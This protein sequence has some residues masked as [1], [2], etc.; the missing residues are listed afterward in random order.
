MA[1]QRERGQ[2]QA[3]ERV[4]GLA[5]QAKTRT[6]SENRVERDIH[7]AADQAQ[8]TMQGATQEVT[9][10]MRN[11]EVRGYAYLAAGLILLAYALGWF[12]ILNVVVLAGAIFGAL[13]GAY[14]ANLPAKVSNLINWTKRQFK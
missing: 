6:S 4:N 9:K 11:T 12:P 2:S 5:E 10:L 14:L 7:G 3:E 8:S 1:N 13:Y